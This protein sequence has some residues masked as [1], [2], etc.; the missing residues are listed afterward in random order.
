MK[1]NVAMSGLSLEVRG[2]RTKPKPWLF[3]GGRRCEGSTEDCKIGL[4][5]LAL[6]GVG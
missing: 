6:D 2:Y 3:F 1:I 5:T 4:S